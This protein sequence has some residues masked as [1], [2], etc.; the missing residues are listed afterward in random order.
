MV[1]KI[2]E[3]FR[4]NG[5][6]SQAVDEFGS[7]A[8]IYAL[9]KKHARLCDIL[10]SNV[11][12]PMKHLAAMKPDLFGR[13]PFSTLLW[14]SIEETPLQP[15]VEIWANQLIA[16][17]ADPNQLCEYPISLSSCP[18]IR[19]TTK[20]TDIIPSNGPRYPPLIMAVISK[21]YRTVKWM[22]TINSGPIKVNINAQDSEGRTALMH[23]V[24]LND[25][26]MVKVLLDSTYDY[27]KDIDGSKATKIKSTKVDPTLQ[28]KKG[29]ALFDYLLFSPTNTY[30]YKNVKQIVMLLNQI[31]ALNSPTVMQ[32][33][34][35]HGRADIVELLA[36][37]GSIQPSKRPTVPPQYLDFAP[38][39][40][41]DIV[42][43]PIHDFN[44]AAE[45]MADKIMEKARE[46]LRKEGGDEEMKLKPDPLCGIEEGSAEV[47]LDDRQNIPYDCLMTKVDLSYGIHGLYNFYKMQ[48]VRQTKGKDIIL[49]FTQWGRVGEQG[50]F[51]KTPFGTEEDAVKEFTKIFKAKSGNAWEDVQNFNP[52]PTKYRLV[53]KD[54]RILKHS[55]QVNVDFEEVEKTGKSIS[56]GAPGSI[57]HLLRNLCLVHRS[58]GS[59]YQSSNRYYHRFNCSPD[60][61]NLPLLPIEVLNRGESILKE[62][63]ELIVLKQKMGE[64][65]VK[66]TEKDQIEVVTKIATL[67]ETFYTIIPVYGFSTEKLEPIFNEDDLR[68]KLQA[69]GNLVHLELAKTLLLAAQYNSTLNSQ[70]PYEYVYR[71]LGPKIQLLDRTNSTDIEEAEII[72]QYI[73]NTGENVKVRGIYRV[74]RSTEDFNLNA[75]KV[76]NRQLLWHGTSAANMLSILHQ[77]IKI[78]PLNSQISGHL[79]GKGIYL[80]DMFAKSQKY[81]RSTD[82]NGKTRKF[83]L[84]CE[85][86]LGKIYEVKLDEASEK[87]MPSTCN[88]LK[89]ADSRYEPDPEATILWKGRTVALGKS[90]EK[91]AR[92][93]DEYWGLDYNE[94]IIFDTNQIAMRYLIE[95]ED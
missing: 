53:K 62:I 11:N 59:T 40:S 87:P 89:T 1:K 15:P 88:S 68:G 6:D 94:Y 67:S 50:Q 80:A 31:G 21:C 85:A 4:K 41:Q 22:L 46:K 66:Y 37:C 47:M 44:V 82:V 7:Q 51:Q 3:S 52:I 60:Y 57:L 5:L 35:Q 71:C 18:G 63:S 42:L 74:Q 70:N 26:R 23:A 10:Y 90:K 61:C 14:N 36:K 27:S 75:T 28:D 2:C 77:G 43:T 24:R 78:A 95:F 92:N 17:G 39:Y 48:L 58:A 84:L 8:I 55:S 32:K 49:L 56:S 54:L 72:L 9:T 12:D 16:A 30:C 93:N 65:R 38:T 34:V 19:F 33:A 86:A 81:C 76:H 69:I 29:K 20:L 45:K 25:T 64:D 91:V 73:H 79:F 83:M 13:T